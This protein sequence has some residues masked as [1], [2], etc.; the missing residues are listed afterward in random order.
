V[1]EKE[2][3]LEQLMEARKRCRDLEEECSTKD[4]DL[5]TLRAGFELEVY[6]DVGCYNVGSSVA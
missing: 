4:E 5:T 1:Q 3:L 6:L 2:H